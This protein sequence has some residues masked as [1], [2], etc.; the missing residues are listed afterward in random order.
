[1]INDA[2]DPN[3]PWLRWA[4]E[5]PTAI[6]LKVA[7]Q[8]YT[9]QAVAEKVAAIAAALQQQGVAADDIVTLVGKNHPDAVWV[10]LARLHAGALSALLPPQPIAMLQRKLE[11]IYRPNQTMWLFCA[12]PS[13]AA[14]LQTQLP[15]C[16]MVDCQ[17]ATS[18]VTPANYHPE[19]LSS[20]IF[21]S[22]STGEPKAVAHTSRQHFASAQGLL[23]QFH[24]TASD[25]WLLSL[26]VYHVSGLSIIYRWLQAGAC[27]RIGRIDD[28]DMTDV[29]HASL[30]PTQLQRLLDQPI[31]HALTHVLLGGSH[32]PPELARR[33]AALGIETWLGYGMTEA[34]STVTAKRV[35]GRE[36]CGSVLPLR[37]VKIDHERIYISGDTLACGYYRQG[38]L[39]PLCDD[40][41]WFDSKDMGYWH[42]QELHVT[43]RVDNLFISGGE[44]IH[45]E[46]IEA[47]LVR[48]PQIDIA[49]VVPVTDATYGARPVA[50]I[51]CEP[52]WQSMSADI[53]A[54]LEGRLEKF[55]WP[56]GYY[57]LPEHFYT[58][59]RTQGIKISRAA[60]KT[61]LNAEIKMC[62]DPDKQL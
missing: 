51:G 11:T 32:I 2:P 6:A 59:G 23:S 39:T 50:V 55:K 42:G 45:C 53:R 37:Q 54:W 35:D 10:F 41:G 52:G 17:L 44:N 40:S 28:C 14:A 21:T 56:D 18:A 29:T 38:T 15:D 58:E 4:I 31:P 26:P 57:R 24:F 47:V 16:R 25:T 19:Q 3:A 5:R 27:L 46:E 48:H 43:G 8:T 22:G 13:E 9:W 34:A 60:V 61:W 20:L 49:V 30:V 33:A 62:R 12:D 7:Q 1:M 36:S